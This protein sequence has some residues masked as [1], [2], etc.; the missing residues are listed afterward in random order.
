ML[1]FGAAAWYFL[2]PPSADTLYARVD[3][4]ARSGDIEQ[5]LEAEDDI[6]SFLARHARDP[7]ARTMEEYKA[8]IELERLQRKLERRS[9][10][11]LGAESLTPVERAYVDA[12]RY[13]RLDPERGREKLQALVDV[14]HDRTAEGGPTEQ[15]LELADRQ[16]EKLN[17]QVRDFAAE[18]LALLESRLDA[19]EELRQRDPQAAR[20]VWEGIVELY[21][22][23]PWAAP[24]VKRAQQ[25][26]QGAP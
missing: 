14:Y 18:S 17:D 22:E 11:T 5:L 25:A 1:A 26:L 16:L 4:R 24:A 23:K 12:I 15:C 9:R 7:R 6:R 8:E 19:A 20:K 2:Q 10:L 13:L 21:R 3:S